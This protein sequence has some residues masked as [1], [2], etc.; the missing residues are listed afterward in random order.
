MLVK[1]KKPTKSKLKEKCDLLASA[2]YRAET[3][4]CELKGLDAIQCG[5]GLQWMHIFSRS[6][7]HMRY[8][9]YNKLVG[10]QGHHLWYTHNPVEWVRFLEANF[11]ERLA[12][13]EAHRYKL[14]KV[15]YEAWIDHFSKLTPNL[16]Q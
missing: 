14:W 6:I 8:E 9:P 11:P 16:Q 1:P 12:Q 2:Y 5:G 7:L 3:P 13:A 4:Y 15:D 10:C